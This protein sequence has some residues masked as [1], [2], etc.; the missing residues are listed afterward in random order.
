MRIVD[1]QSCSENQVTSFVARI[2]RLCLLLA[3]I[4]GSQIFPTTSHV[5]SV[6]DQ[7]YIAALAA[8]N[9]FLQAWQNQDHETAI[10]LLSD[11]L[12]QHTREEALETFFTPADHAQ[13]AYEI[14]SGKKIAPGRYIF[15]VKLF[16][17]GSKAAP[18]KQ[19]RL[20]V[21][22]TGKNDWAIDKLP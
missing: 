17:S 5:R 22:R 19:S 16:N 3:L 2:I 21:T 1:R 8:A 15:I 11:K 18:H 4:A 14:S 10:I 7:D 13:Q 20:I 6:I 9:R 12:K